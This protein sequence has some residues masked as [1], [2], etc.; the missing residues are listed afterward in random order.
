MVNQMEDSQ[1]FVVVLISGQVIISSISSIS[2]ELG[3][4]DC[5]LSKPFLIGDGNNLV[6]WLKSYTFEDEVIISSDKI[7]TIVEPTEELFDTYME[8]TK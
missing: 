7:L 3:E 8:N 4:P 6:P 1:V 5:K 2:S